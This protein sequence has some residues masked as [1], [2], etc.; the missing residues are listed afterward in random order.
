MRHERAKAR[1][2]WAMGLSLIVPAALYFLLFYVLRWV[3]R[4]FVAVT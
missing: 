1:W 4:G 2:E 3:Y